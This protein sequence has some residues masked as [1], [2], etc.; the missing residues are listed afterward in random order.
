M[1][2][3]RLLKSAVAKRNGYI[4]ANEVLNGLK[5]KTLRHSLLL[6]VYFTVRSLKYL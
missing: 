5:V 6:Y 3:L 1:R 4:G 2:V